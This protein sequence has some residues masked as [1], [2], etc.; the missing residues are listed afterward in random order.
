MDD[1]NKPK[2]DNE[3]KVEITKDIIYKRLI[4]S[5]I[6]KSPGP[7]NLHPRV[8]KEIS[9]VLVDP[10]FYIFNLSLN[11]GKLPKEWKKAWITPVFKNKGSKHDAGK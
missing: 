7:D 10:L 9:S 8:L 1:D 6:N 3:L 4:N 5:N 11:T 2:I